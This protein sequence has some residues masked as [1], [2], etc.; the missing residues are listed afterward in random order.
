MSVLLLILGVALLLVC[1]GLIYIAYVRPQSDGR[2]PGCIPAIA[3]LLA[4]FVATALIIAALA[5]PEVAVRW[6]TT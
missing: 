5:G 1:L 2:E 4:G 6:L 3:A